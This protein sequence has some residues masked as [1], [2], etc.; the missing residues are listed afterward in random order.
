M[1]GLPGGLAGAPEGDSQEVEWATGW[2]RA[3]GGKGRLVFLYSDA[4]RQHSVVG[5]PARLLRH[6]CEVGARSYSI[7]CMLYLALPHYQLNEA[8]GNNRLG[9]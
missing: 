3:V 9:G 4:P 8:T 7:M 5:Q 6:S 2:A 1:D